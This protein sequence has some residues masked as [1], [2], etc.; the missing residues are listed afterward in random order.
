MLKKTKMI[1]IMMFYTIIMEL[2]TTCIFA[3]EIKTFNHD[4]LLSDY[5]KASDPDYQK[6][7]D[8]GLPYRIMYKD[9][10]TGKITYEYFNCDASDYESEDDKNND[11]KETKSKKK[12]RSDLNSNEINDENVMVNETINWEAEIQKQNDESKN[13]GWIQFNNAWYYQDENGANKKGWQYIGDKWY[14][15]DPET[16]VMTTGLKEINGLKYWFNDDG[17]MAINHWVK[18][19]GKDYYFD[20]DGHMVTNEKR[21]GTDG[22][23]RYFDGNGVSV[24]INEFFNYA[25]AESEL[26]GNRNNCINYYNMYKDIGF[27]ALPALKGSLEVYQSLLNVSYRMDSIS[28]N[29]RGC[30]EVRKA[31]AEL[32]EWKRVVR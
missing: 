6:Y 30:D 21:K 22:T 14:Y 18:M 32:E 25:Y 8:E 10:N 13:V 15:L 1:I 24:V 28:G 9:Y 23:K 20:S 29:Q 3:K 5:E 11:S 16:Y 2:M 7:V 4:Y 26:N 12:K 19:D 31:F 17:S 27:P